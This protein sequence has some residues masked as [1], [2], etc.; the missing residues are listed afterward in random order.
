MVHVFTDCLIVKVHDIIIV[1][2]ELVLGFLAWSSLLT[3]SVAKETSLE[4]N[5]VPDEGRI[6][7]FRNIVCAYWGQ[8]TVP[9]IKVKIFNFNLLGAQ[10]HK[11]ILLTATASP[12]T[13]SLNMTHWRRMDWRSAPRILNHYVG[14]GWMDRFTLKATLCRT[15]KSLQFQRRFCGPQIRWWREYSRTPLIRT[16]LIRIVIYL[17]RLDHPGKFVQNSTKLTC[18]EITGYRIKYS[19]VLWLVEL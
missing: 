6:S 8:Q 10:N 17:D 3:L 1:C 4:R 18:L 5:Y 2:V 16:L 15:K 9:K 19:T 14:Y 7:S 11:D 13:A 12:V